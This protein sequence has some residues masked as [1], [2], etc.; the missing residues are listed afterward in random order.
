MAQGW[1]R[2]QGPGGIFTHHVSNRP[3]SSPLTPP[4]TAA[5][6]PLLVLEGI[7][8]RYPSVVANDAVSLRVMPGEIHAVL[9]ENGAG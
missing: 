6:M 9:G 2:G 4:P 5:P 1:H 8:K 7:T 3:M